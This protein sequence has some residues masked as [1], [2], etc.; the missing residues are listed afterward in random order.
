M[1]T[2]LTDLMKKG[3]TQDE[4]FAVIFESERERKR[5]HMQA[6][7]TETVAAHRLQQMGDLLTFEK[8]V[9]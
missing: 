9:T 8:L 7:A 2:F 3:F 5:R 1:T 6:I 4:I